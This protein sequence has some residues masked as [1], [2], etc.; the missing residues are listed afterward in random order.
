V[1][2][3]LK[4]ACLAALY[5]A[6][7]DAMRRFSFACRI[8]C[9]QCCT[10]NVL[11]TTLE[12][13]LF[14]EALESADR[15]DLI[16]RAMA[17]REASVAQ[18]VITANQFAAL[19]LRKEEP[20]DVLEHPTSGPCPFRET[21]GCPVYTARP[22]E[23]RAMWSHIPCSEDA[24]VMDPLLI[25]LSLMFRQLVEDLDRGGLYGN[26][27]DLIVHLRVPANRTRYRSGL[28]LTPVAGFTQTQPN[29]GLLVPPEHRRDAL[30]ALSNLW[31]RAVE[32]IPFKVAVKAIQG[33]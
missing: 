27:L 18:S 21:S 30:A 26:A 16:D 8:E 9:S 14:L 5:D 24:A 4:R 17:C 33:S 13:D 3:A 15:T 7:D 25:T 12:V 23:C 2:L 10:R 11:A 32:G 28:K 20:P 1:T 6:Y 19:C 29:P 31:D 22:F